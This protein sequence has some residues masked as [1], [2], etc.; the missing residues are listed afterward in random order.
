MS[1]VVLVAVDRQHLWLGCGLPAGAGSGSKFVYTS[2]DSGQT[3]T[4]KGKGALPPQED[5]TLSTIGY[6]SG[7][8]ALSPSFAYMTWN[9]TLAVVITR[10]GGTTWESS[11]LPRSLE[12]SKA[13]FIDPL[14]G[15]AFDQVWINRTVDGGKTWECVEL[16]ESKPCALP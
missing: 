5:N 16:P 1:D 15:W 8:D 10:D 4:L 3:W 14:H 2:S 12:F 9:R 11:S 7:L 6:F 13:V